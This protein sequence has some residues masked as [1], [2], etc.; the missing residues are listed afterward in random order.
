[1]WTRESL[2]ELIKEK[3]SDYLFI[4]VSNR[5]PYVHTFKKGK[6]EVMR[7]AGG[8]V[9]ALDPVMQACQGTWVTYGSGDADRKA[10]GPDGGVLVPPDNPQ[11][12]LK[13]VF[14]T[15]EEE[16]GYYYGYSNEAI[17]P[18]CHLTFQRPAFRKEDWEFYRQ[19]NKKFAQAVL[20]EVGDRKAFIW[21]QDYHL[22]LLPKLLK[23]AAGDRLKIAHFWHIPWPNYEV[24]RVCPQKHDILEG[25][26][27]NDLMGFHIRYH[28][29][30]FFDCLDRETEC[31]IDRE[32]LSVTKAGHETL[33]RPYPISIDFD[34]INEVSQQKEIDS[35]IEAFRDEYSL[36][37]LKIISGID[38][39]DY[40][41]GIPERIKAL[42]LLLDKCP[43]LKGKVVFLQMG[44]ISRI[45]LQRYKDLNDEINALVEQINW[46]YATDNWK[47][48]IL[49]RRHLS[50]KEILA[51]YR[52]TDVCVVSSL[53]DGMNLVSKEFVASRF[54]GRGVLV[55]TQF[56]GSARELTD[57]IL[58]N[59]YDLESMS[60][61]FYQGLCL[62][63]DEM[64]RRMSRMREVVRFNNIFRW[65][66]KN[67]SELLRFEFKE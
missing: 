15:K 14:L 34:G 21:I 7:G 1:M 52:L 63:E 39:F 67:I 60:D 29:N 47:P 65:A 45:H 30:N 31:K 27:A 3:L 28:L 26:L 9:T 2:K 48:V 49:L 66:G 61:G 41:K 59:P 42:D 5:E 10:S 40:T 12:R 19:V 62:P 23:E 54:D 17:W 44:E 51:F 53:H 20:D 16:K 50:Y 32:R 33:V 37:G 11:Y 13:R 43:D 18:L 6:I 8:V 25:L 58:V 36:R 56:A 57:A 46:K 64:G 55:L 24:F 22:V 35:I 4:V 38:R